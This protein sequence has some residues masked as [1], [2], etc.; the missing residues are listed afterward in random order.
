MCACVAGEGGITFLEMSPPSFLYE[1]E[2]GKQGTF[3]ELYLGNYSITSFII[4]IRS[5][6]KVPID[7]N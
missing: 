7:F 4:M 6:S 1:E 3:L 5:F 2:T